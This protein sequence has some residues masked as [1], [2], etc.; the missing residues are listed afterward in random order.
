MHFWVQRM[1]E[2]LHC[3]AGEKIKH[4]VLVRAIV[5]IDKN[6]GE[7]E[8]TKEKIRS[9]LR[10]KNNDLYV[11]LV[12]L[13]KDLKDRNILLIVDQSSLLSVDVIDDRKE[14]LTE[15]IRSA[16]FSNNETK[17]SA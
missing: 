7:V 17:V 3:W 4:N 6:D 13:A 12:F 1:Q 2:L 10:T 14:I 11:S 8:V 16:T 5:H 15:M 9:L